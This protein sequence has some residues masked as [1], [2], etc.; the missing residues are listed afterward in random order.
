MKVYFPKTTRVD[1]DFDGFVEL[2]IRTYSRYEDCGVDDGG[3]WMNLSLGDDIDPCTGVNTRVLA[4][5]A[6]EARK[7]EDQ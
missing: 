3:F 6:R 1:F 7:L 5:K 2:N 4:E